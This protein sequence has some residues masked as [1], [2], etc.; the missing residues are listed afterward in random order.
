[1]RALC[2]RGHRTPPR[3]AAA[4]RAGALPADIMAPAG[5]S[6]SS[7]GRPATRNTTTSAAP[8]K[9]QRTL[10]WKADRPLLRLADRTGSVSA[11][12]LEGV[13]EARPACRAGEVAVVR[14]I[15]RE[16][17]RFGPRVVVEAIRS[18]TPDEY[19]AG[20]LFDGPPRPAWGLVADLRELA[21]TVQRPHLQALLAALLGEGTE[22]WARFRE[23]PAAKYY[24][25]AYR[26]GLLEHSLTVAQG[27]SAISAT[28]P[29]IDRD[30]AVVGALLQI[31]HADTTITV[32]SFVAILLASINI[33]GG[34]AVTRRM[35]SMF[36]KG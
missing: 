3:R 29:G 1:M 34:F 30:V 24:H 13:A 18:A 33:F 12:V 19:V 36:S 11:V 16:D 2:A 27:V 7:N 23:A 15:L 28:F 20:D 22:T 31:G 17:E 25:Q 6:R 21:A 5:P 14:G 26:H 9:D 4:A 8:D 35:L 10:A 32:L